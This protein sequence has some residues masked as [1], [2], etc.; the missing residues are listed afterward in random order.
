MRLGRAVLQHGSVILRGDQAAVSRLSGGREAGPPP[1]SVD[2]LAHQP[3][4][5]EQ[6][7]DALAAGLRLA[8]GG[9]WTEGGYQSWEIEAADRLEAERYATDEWTWRR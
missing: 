4:D 2:A 5:E 6:L 9:S 1:A 7:R 3:V 8:L